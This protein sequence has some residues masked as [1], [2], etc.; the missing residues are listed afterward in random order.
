MK[1]PIE[2]VYRAVGD[3][4]RRARVARGV[5]QRQLGARVGHSRLSM[6]AIETARQRVQVH[7]LFAIADALGVAVAELLP[8]GSQHEQ[9]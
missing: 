7:T 9:A 2:E 8:T 1:R 3:R 6:V 5:T 4:V